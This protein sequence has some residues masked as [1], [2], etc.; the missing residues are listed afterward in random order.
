[1][2]RK[3]YVRLDKS[4]AQTIW[5][6]AANERRDPRDQIA[7]MLEQQVKTMEDGKNDPNATKAHAES[8]QAYS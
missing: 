1:M 3:V 8:H 4:T 5:Q 7:I 2:W 6:I